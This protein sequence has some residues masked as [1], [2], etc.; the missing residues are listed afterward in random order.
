MSNIKEIITNLTKIISELNSDKYKH[1]ELLIQFKN[2]IQS[3]V[4]KL[5]LKLKQC[6]PSPHNIIH[7]DINK[8]CKSGS[9]SDG[10][11]MLNS[12]SKYC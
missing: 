9:E 3:L 6:K 7:N 11:S 12:I 10:C 2:N 8:F 5:N 4:D 1:N